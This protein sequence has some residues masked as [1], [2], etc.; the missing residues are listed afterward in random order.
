MPGEM[1]FDL[2]DIK[3]TIRDQGIKLSLHAYEEAFADG[4]SVDEIKEAL[5]DGTIV[6]DYPTWPLLPGLR[7]NSDGP[8]PAFG[9]DIVVSTRTGYHGI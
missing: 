6:E 7:P 2:D 3:R 4:V 1:E 8:R 5:L 9:S